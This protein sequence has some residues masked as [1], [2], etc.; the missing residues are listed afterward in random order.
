MEIQIDE[1]SG[2][3][4]GVVNAVKIAEEQLQRH[5]TL[6]CLGDIVHNNM[7]IDRLTRKGLVIIS[8]DDLKNIFNSRVLIRAHGEPPETYR[9]ARE[10]NIEIIDAT[11]P[12]VLKLQQ[13]I[14]KG[15]AAFSENKVQ[16]VI[17][18]K[19][20][21]AEVNGLIGQT[22]GEA[23]VVGSDFSNL[24]KIDYSLPINLYSQTTQSL[25]EFQNLIAEIK[26]R[27]AAKG[28]NPEENFKPSDTICRQVANRGPHLVEFANKYEVIIF[29]SGKNSSNGLY[30]YNICKQ[31]NDNSHLISSPDELNLEWFEGK[32]N[33]GICGATSTPRWLM[34]EVAERIALVSSQKQEGKS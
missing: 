31:H 1:K 16:I 33:V 23:I 6:Y 24:D 12:V 28:F 18:G 26:K 14:K 27:I 29:V 9:L 19:H 13:K 2:F 30:L 25:S 21:H 5:G 7:E 15:H 34:D 10:N 22:N 8:H 17:F 3:C 20:G 4:F 32:K 11:C